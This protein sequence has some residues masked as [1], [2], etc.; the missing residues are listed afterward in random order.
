MTK[1][2]KIDAIETTDLGLAS[3]LTASGHRLLETRMNEGSVTF[4]FQEDVDINQDIKGYFLGTLS[5]SAFQYYEDMKRL[6][7]LIGAHFRAS[8]NE[9]DYVSRGSVE[10]EKKEPVEE[11]EYKSYKI[12]GD[13]YK[14]I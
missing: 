8:V 1:K 14:K 10:V 13:G 2:E 9:D 7:K 5:V 12:S 3:A 6:R 11:K 4:Y